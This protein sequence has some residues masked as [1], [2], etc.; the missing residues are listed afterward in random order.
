MTGLVLLLLGALDGGVGAELAARQLTAQHRPQPFDGGVG[1]FFHSDGCPAAHVREVAQRVVELE[2]ERAPCGNHVVFPHAVSRVTLVKAPAGGPVV[3]APSGDELRMR[4]NSV[5]LGKTCRVVPKVQR[6][7]RWE[8]FWATS[9]KWA[10]V[11]GAG[12]LGWWSNDPTPHEDPPDFL[13]DL[14]KKTIRSGQFS[15]LGP[16]APASRCKQSELFIP[17]SDGWLC[18]AEPLAHQLSVTRHRGPRLERCDAGLARPR[19]VGVFTCSEAELVLL[20]L[21][22]LDACTELMTETP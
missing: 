19:P 4:G 6:V 18:V 15:L 7:W 8:I 14:E 22:D 17:R 11:R 9:G 10:L 1:T 3:L 12:E 21:F 16:G 5:C 20:G 13:L 2:L